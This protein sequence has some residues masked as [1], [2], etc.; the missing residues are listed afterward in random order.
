VV[1][2]QLFVVQL[3]GTE[4]TNLRAFPAARAFTILSLFDKISLIAPVL[5]WLYKVHATIVTTKAYT[6]GLS[7]ILFVSKRS[8]YQ[9]LVFGFPENLLYLS[10]G[11]LP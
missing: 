1:S 6:V 9:M 7:H 8:G 4:V 11:D 2:D 5:T 3:S 10:P